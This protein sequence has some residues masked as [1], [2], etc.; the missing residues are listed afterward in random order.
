MIQMLLVLYFG[1]VK[2][3]LFIMLD[4]KNYLKSMKK[5]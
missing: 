2:E 1:Y 4:L 5:N 3:K